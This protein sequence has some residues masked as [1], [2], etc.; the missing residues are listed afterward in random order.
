MG[1]VKN[2][3]EIGLQA[4]NIFKRDS[5]TGVSCGICET[6]KNSGGCFWKHGTYYYINYPSSTPSFNSIGFI[7]NLMIRHETG[8]WCGMTLR[9]TSWQQKPVSETKR[10][11][12]HPVLYWQELIPFNQRTCRIIFKMCFSRSCIPSQV[13]RHI[14][15][16]L[17]THR[18]TL[19]TQ[20]CQASVTL[21]HCILNLNHHSK[22][23]F[24]PLILLWD[25]VNLKAL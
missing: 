17:L 15:E 8:A 5:N 1:I 10:S 3:H 7:V 16:V 21:H 24:M 20:N 2:K 13:T 11:I 18:H 6:F 22:N 14:L 4:C 23:E 25:M 12:A 19:V 9:R